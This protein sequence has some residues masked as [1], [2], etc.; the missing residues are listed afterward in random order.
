METSDWSESIMYALS[1]LTGPTS[2]S[3]ALSSNGR[4]HTRNKRKCIS[5][6]HAHRIQRLTFLPLFLSPSNPQTKRKNAHTLKPH[7]LRFLPHNSQPFL[8]CLQ[9]CFQNLRSDFW[10]CLF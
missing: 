8:I 7:S 2:S 4:N 10:V 5:K 9:F 3:R 1:N 6:N